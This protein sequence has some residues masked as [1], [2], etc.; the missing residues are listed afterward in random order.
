MQYCGKLFDNLNRLADSPD[1]ERRLVRELA[2]RIQELARAPRMRAVKQRWKDVLA[3]RKADRPPVWCNPVGCWAELLPEATIVCRDPVCRELEVHCKRVLIKA[4][5]GDDTPIND[6]YMVESVLDV[7]PANTWGVDILRERLD[8]AG[9]AW[10][11]RPALETAADFGR[12]VVP[13]YRFNQEA[14]AAACDRRREVLEDALAVVTSPIAGYYSGGTL[15]LPAAELRGM[16]PLMLDMIEAPELVH[17]LMD[18]LCR[19]ELARLDAAEASGRILPNT[20]SAMFLSE[21]V[22]DNNS[23]VY[24]LRDCWVH[25]NSQEL[26]PVG[27]SMFAE[28][29]LEYQKRVFERFGA[30]CYGCCEN[31]TRKLDAVLEIPNLRLLTCSAWTD[32]PTLVE[33][34]GG[35]CCIMWRHK[36]SDVVCPDTTDSLKKIVREQA[37]LLKNC[38]YQAVLRELQTLMGHNDRLR[39]WTLLTTEAVTA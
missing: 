10:R 20:D 8:A 34:A 39:E 30:V 2:L 38:R 4:E 31:L 6:T 3:N 21:P 27:P 11:Y 5:I 35:R 23:G 16:E 9:A 25:G 14:T 37:R 19:G 18:I 36:A 7:A 12:L 28:F 15:C 26:D 32:M 17:K 1:G 33:K 29:L 13:A 22:R 24:D